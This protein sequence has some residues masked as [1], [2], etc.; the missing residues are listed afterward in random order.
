MSIT[1]YRPPCLS[2]DELRAIV[3]EAIEKAP[4]NVNETYHA[5][6]DHLERG[7]TSDDVVHGLEREWRF[8][9]APEFSEAN[10]QW[11]YRIL[12]ETIEGDVLVILIAVDT[13]NRSFE[14]ITR[15]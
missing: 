7:I 3:L 5:R 6:F 8:E 10:W 9:R 4:E 11:K 1:G 12:T 14:V 2:E 13:S 15:W